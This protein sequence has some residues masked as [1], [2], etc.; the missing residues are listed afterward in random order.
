MVVQLSARNAAAA[1]AIVRLCSHSRLCTTNNVRHLVNM[2]FN[3]EGK[4]SVHLGNM[5]FAWNQSSSYVDDSIAKKMLEAFVAGGGVHFDTAR[6]YAAGKSE[7]MTGRVLAKAPKK[8][9]SLS[10]ATK[11]HPSQLDGLSEEG[12]KG[13]LKLS[14]EAMQLSKVNV[15]YLH[16]PDTKH[17]LTETLKAMSEIIASGAVGGFGLSNFS[18]AEVARCVQI[19][20]ENN[21]PLPLVYQGLYNP[22]NRRVEADLLPLLREHGI[23]FVA[24]NILAGGL[25][26]GKHSRDGD[27]Q[28]GRFKDNAFYY[29]RFY[30][31]DHFDALDKIRAAVDAAG[32]SMT[33]A[34]YA[35][36]VHHSKLGSGDGVLLG[37]SKFEHLEQNL[38]C[39][40]EAEPLSAAVVEAFDAGWKLCEEDAFKF[41]RGYSVDHPDW[42][43]LD[44]GALGASAKKYG[45]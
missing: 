36:M 41:W 23:H 14:L 19:C 40:N 10:I 43:N 45:K 3:D 39:F 5:T 31:A 22:V 21:Y 27:V 18:T 7:E 29:D 17:P 28:K 6:I 9:S 44:S 8:F 20:K 26:T 15:L 16:S 33:Q 25:L 38:K 32:I 42:E 35:W 11:A 1:N 37:A 13:Q 2:A 12:L 30:K 24:Y 4:P 34:A